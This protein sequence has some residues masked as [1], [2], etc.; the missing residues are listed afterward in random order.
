MKKNI[1]L[2]LRCERYKAGLL[3]LLILLCTTSKPSFAAL[4]ANSCSVAILGAG[5]ETPF[6]IKALPVTLTNGFVLGTMNFSV[7][8]KYTKTALTSD[9][10]HVGGWSLAVQGSALPVATT[11]PGVKM[12]VDIDG[13]V[14]G[15]YAWGNTTVPLVLTAPGTQV[16]RN[17]RVTAQLIVTDASIYQGGTIN[18]FGVQRDFAVVS[19][20]DQ[21]WIAKNVT[22]GGSRCGGLVTFNIGST[23]IVLPPPTV[24]TCNL[25]ATDIVVALD[26]VD[27]S[28]LQ[29]QGDRVGGQ[30][31]S[32]P[33]GS[34]AKDAKPYIT[35]TDS[36]NK[37]NRTNILSLSPSSTATGVGLVLEKSDGNLVTFGAENASV[38]A[39]NV[40]QFLIG[41]STAAGGSMPLNLTARYIRSEGV[42]K[43][44]NVKADAI[45]TVAYP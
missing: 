3:L 31:F 44:G 42:L 19:G 14:F 37:A 38:S 39:S 13:A 20:N 22:A 33:L 16:T 40:G 4:I 9:Y 35:F 45:F 29:T 21:V 6:V 1:F 15:G 5:G 10:L 2:I 43:S 28:S 7:A 36:S 12:S 18:W 11:V 41:T 26:P 24:A 8:T 27:T 23:N 34:C 17:S 30:A 32:I 25:G